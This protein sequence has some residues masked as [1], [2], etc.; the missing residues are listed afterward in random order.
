VQARAFIPGWGASPAMW[1]P[2]GASVP[3]GPG[4][5]VVGWSLGAMHALEAAL[6]ADVA[7]LV[8]VAGTPQFVRRGAWRIGWTP[9]ILERM[10]DV[11]AVDPD[12][13]LD[14]F[15]AAMWAPGEEP[16]AIPRETDPEALAAGLRYL[17]QASLLDRLGDVRCPVRLLHGG[18]DRLIPVAAAETLAAALPHADLTVWAE[19]GH[20]P[21]LTQ[22]DRFRAW[23]DA[24]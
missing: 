14:D 15:E 20:A 5:E 8:L 23:L 7:G 9:R 12:R 10:L 11:L 4:V 18:A 21:H 22:P 13:L 6:E 3:P 2:F 24:T 1:E 17:D 19:A 16:I